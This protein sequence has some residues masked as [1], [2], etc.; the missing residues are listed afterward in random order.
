MSVQGIWKR[1]L[2]CKQLSLKGEAIAWEGT[3]AHIR[4]GVVC[5][6]IWYPYSDRCIHHRPLCPPCPRVDAHSSSQPGCWG[7]LFQPPDISLLSLR[8]HFCVF[9][10]LPQF[11]PLALRGTTETMS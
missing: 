8:A 2:E 10:F 3:V 4:S 7:C 1:A 6:W 5:R 9:A 11:R